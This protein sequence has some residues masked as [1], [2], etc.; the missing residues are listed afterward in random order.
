MDNIIT[1]L[2]LD[3]DSTYDN[4]EPDNDGVQP[5]IYAVPQSRLEEVERLATESGQG[6]N[7]SDTD[8][9]IGDIFERKMIDAGITFQCIG[10]LDLSFEERQMD[11]LAD[12]LLHVVV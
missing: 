2:T 8:D 4:E 10:S 3:F 7:D 6:F 5:L 12:Y 11:Y 9:C 1:Y